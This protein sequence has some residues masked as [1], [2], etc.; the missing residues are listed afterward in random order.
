[1][2]GGG[3]GGTVVG[4]VPGGWVAGGSGGGG[5]SLVAV[6]GGVDGGSRSSVVLDGCV[7]PVVGTLEVVEVVAGPSSPARATTRAS[8]ATRRAAIEPISSQR[9]RLPTL[10]ACAAGRRTHRAERPRATDRSDGSQARNER[11]G[12]DHLVLGLLSEPDAIAARVLA[13]LGADAERVRGAVSL[14]AGVEGAPSLVPYDEPA[15][16]V[17]ELTFREAPRLGHDYVGTEHLLLALLEHEAGE[18]PLSS[19]GVTKEDVEAKVRE[20]LRGLT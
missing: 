4:G 9:E 12:T 10:P 17:L 6:G 13:D 15:K 20:A 8:V 1:M 3:S 5:T 2:V 19:L 7:V 14:P 11:V 18:G 16:K